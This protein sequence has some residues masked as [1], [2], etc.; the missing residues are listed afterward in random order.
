MGTFS[1]PDETACNPLQT[2]FSW[3]TGFRCRVRE[4]SYI[5][6]EQRTFPLSQL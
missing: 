5:R 6:G 4:G 3:K 1:P 2:E